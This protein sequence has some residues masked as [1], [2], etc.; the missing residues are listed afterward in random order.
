[1]PRRLV[2]AVV[3]FGF[4]GFVAIIIIEMMI[5]LI[6]FQGFSHGFVAAPP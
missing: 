5:F 2:G 6:D 3:G 1:M 4:F